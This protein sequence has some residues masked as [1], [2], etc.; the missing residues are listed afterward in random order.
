MCKWLQSDDMDYE[1]AN[2]QLFLYVLVGVVAP[3]VSACI[4]IWHREEAFWRCLL[5]QRFS[6]NRYLKLFGKVNLRPSWVVVSFS[7]SH[8]FNHLL[9]VTLAI[10]KFYFGNFERA[11]FFEK[12]HNL[13]CHFFFP[14]L[15][16]RL[17]TKRSSE[18]RKRISRYDPST[19][20]HQTPI[21]RNEVKVLGLLSQDNHYSNIDFYR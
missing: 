3:I 2:S 6:L 1:Y 18:N 21:F 16:R 12:D 15:D 9:L 14:L 8:W 19:N 7:W 20:K 4:T 10:K 5:S 11:T 13:K 17:E